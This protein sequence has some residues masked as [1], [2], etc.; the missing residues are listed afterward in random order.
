MPVI[1]IPAENGQSF[2]AYISL[3]EKTPSPA[4]IVIQEIFGV[5]ADMRAWCD[6]LADQG[7][8]A[9]C[10]D[11]FWRIEPGVE[12]HDSVESENLKAFDL[13]NKFD[14]KTGLQDLKTTLAFIRKHKNCNGLVAS[15]GFCLGGKLAYLLAANADINATV[16]YY[17]VGIAAALDQASSIKAPI[18]LHMAGDDEFVPQEAQ[19]K[20]QAVMDEHPLAQIWHYAGLEHAFARKNGIHYNA[21]AAAL[22][23][24]RTDAFL[25]DA[26]GGKTA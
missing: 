11:L 14:E 4:V 6:H 21:E 19:D 5:N 3:P 12:L 13:Y 23:S 15:V 20:I 9:I 17:G 26:I 10:P 2:S 18:L 8:V 1:Q 24:E 25:K 22:A 16:S 7:Y